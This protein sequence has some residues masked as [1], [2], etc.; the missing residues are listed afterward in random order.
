MALR[1]KHSWPR[2]I[3]FCVYLVVLISLGGFLLFTGDLP[4]QQVHP[5]ANRDAIVVLTGGRGR[6]QVGLKMLAAGRGTRL[7]ISGVKSGI[8]ATE[9]WN[10]QAEAADLFSCCVDLGYQAHNTRGN[11]IETEL[12]A[13]SHGYR[14]LYLVTAAYHMPRSLLLFEEAM[15]NIK[16][17]TVPVLP[18]SVKL[19]QWWSYP[20]TLKLLII[21]YSKYLFSLI[22]VRLVSPAV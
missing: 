20:G 19:H 1:R 7:L 10:I 17:D 4:R 8:S 5:S 12:W 21:E 18:N 15:P 11:A 2:L 16:F 3:F 22:R 6:L 9:L 14:S 13:K